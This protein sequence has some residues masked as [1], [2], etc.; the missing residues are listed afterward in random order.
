MFEFLNAIKQIERWYFK[1]KSFWITEG[2]VVNYLISF[3]KTNK[4]KKN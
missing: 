3:S 1:I 2:V 4:E